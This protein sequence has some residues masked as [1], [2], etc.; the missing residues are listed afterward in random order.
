MQKL[1]IALRSHS[2]IRDKKQDHFEWREPY[3]LNFLCILKRR[4]SSYRRLLIYYV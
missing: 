1:K 3:L 2:E 4:F